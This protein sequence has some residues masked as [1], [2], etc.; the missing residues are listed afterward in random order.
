MPSTP[1]KRARVTGRVARSGLLRSTRAKKN[2]FQA[3]MNANSAVAT[4]PGASNGATTLR[5]ACRRVAPST[6]AASSRSRGTLRTKP[7]SIQSANGSA[8]T[9]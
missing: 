8:H 2:S 9:T 3:E 4:M 1:T 5:S 7:C 6:A